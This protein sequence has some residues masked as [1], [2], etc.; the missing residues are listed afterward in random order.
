M[1][2]SKKV[3]SFGNDD[4]YILN[5][6]NIDFDKS[7][8]L[9]T[10]QEPTTPKKLKVVDM[11]LNR[12]RVLQSKIRPDGKSNTGTI[13]PKEMQSAM[14]E[15]G[16]R[17]I[18]RYPMDIIQAHDASTQ[19]FHNILD[20]SSKNMNA[21]ALN[22]YVFLWDLNTNT[23]LSYERNRTTPL[24]SLSWKQDGSHLAVSKKHYLDILGGPCSDT[25]VR[26]IAT[27]FSYSSMNWR[28]DLVT[29]GCNA[30]IVDSYDLR[31]SSD[32]PAFSLMKSTRANSRSPVVSVKWNPSGRY[33]ATSDAR[34]INIWD[35]LNLKTSL[36]TFNQHKSAVKALAWCP[37]EAG[38]LAT[39]GGYFDGKMYVWNCNSGKVSGSVN[40][41]SQITGL[42]W[43]ETDREILSAHARRGQSTEHD[44]FLY[45]KIH[46]WKY[47]SSKYDMRRLNHSLINTE[48]VISITNNQRFLLA[49]CGFNC[50]KLYLWEKV[51][52]KVPSQL[53][54]YN[55]TDLNK[56]K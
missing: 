54:K 40:L 18:R 9:L 46:F 5:R 27:D 6:N 34:G 38:S 20:L 25:L 28:E 15:I 48:E 35:V 1:N 37:Y 49:L 56:F 11:N 55:L 31:R 7:H 45:N 51:F 39:G 12:T 47:Q 22:D 8:L 2:M 53:V 4:R 3:L 41:N 19:F 33:L 24:T 44:E 14:P 30:S 50:P 29:C 10:R 23:Y 32:K 36:T 42:I 13:D 17:R 52:N 26:R 43:S 16:E 21:I